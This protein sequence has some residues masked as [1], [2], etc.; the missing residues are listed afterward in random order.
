MVKAML[1]IIGRE[2]LQGYYQAHILTL[3]SSDSIAIFSTSYQVAGA[4]VR[5]LKGA[6]QT[7]LTV[8]RYLTV[9]LALLC[10]CTICSGQISV[11]IN[12]FDPSGPWYG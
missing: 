12:E 6:N 7:K 10:V 4:A 5:C 3:T 8:M 2:Q 11:L 9:L 1:P